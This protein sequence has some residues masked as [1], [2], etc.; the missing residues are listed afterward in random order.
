MLDNKNNAVEYYFGIKSNYKCKRR[1]MS[2][3][4]FK[5]FICKVYKCM[6]FSV[7]SLH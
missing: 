7:F 4:F 1:I 2:F 6:N 5:G 3:D